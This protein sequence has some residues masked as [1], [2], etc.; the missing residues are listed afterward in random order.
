MEI[1]GEIYHTGL[2]NRAFYSTSQVCSS[3]DC[4]SMFDEWHV[5]EE[6][7]CG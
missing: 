1:E 3:G 5:D 7:D 4:F 6:N 2:K